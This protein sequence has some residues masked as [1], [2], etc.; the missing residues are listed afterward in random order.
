MEVTIVMSLIVP[1]E[2]LTQH[3]DLNKGDPLK[4]NGIVQTKYKE[5]N[6]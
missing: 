2:I 1:M 4:R 6:L 5:I 3:I